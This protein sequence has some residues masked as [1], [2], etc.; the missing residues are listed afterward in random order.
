MKTYSLLKFLNEPVAD[1]LDSGEEYCFKSLSYAAE[2]DYN[3][4]A[5]SQ[6]SVPVIQ[7]DYAQG[8]PENQTMREK[9]IEKIFT[10]LE[11]GEQ[12]KLD[13]IYGT[14]QYTPYG[15]VFMPLDG[16]QRLTTLYL[17]HWYII[18][19][20]TPEESEDYA[21]FNELLSKFSYETRDTSRR[22]F[23]ELIDFSPNGP[24]DRSI[25]DSYWFS[26]HFELDPTV[27][28]VINTLKT[29]EETYLNSI[30]RG[31]LLESL[32]TD[33]IVFYV[34]PMDKFKLTDDL[35]IKLNARGKILSSF[36]NFKADYIG[37][38]KKQKELETD[39]KL[40]NG[41]TMPHYDYIANKFDNDWTNLFWQEAKKQKTSKKNME[42]ADFLD[43]YF[44]RFIHRLFINNFLLTY[45]GSDINKDPVYKELLRKEA[46]LT[47]SDFDF[48]TEHSLISGSTVTE[49]EILLDFYLKH[50]ETIKNLV[51]PLWEISLQWDIYKERYTMTERMIFDAVNHYIINNA[52]D[53]D[54]DQERF[55]EWIRIVWNL[56][57]DPDIRSIEANKTVMG[58]IRSISKYSGRFHSEI[59]TGALDEFITS[60]RNIH[61]AQLQEEKHKAALMEGDS[62]EAKQWKHLIHKAESHKLFEGSIGF[63]LQDAAVPHDLDR[64]LALAE[65][66]F[67]KNRPF[68]LLK[69]QQHTLMRYVIARFKDYSELSAFNFSDNEIN[70]KTYLRRNETVKGIISELINLPSIKEACDK[71]QQALVDNSILVN[72]NSKESKAH[73]NLYSDNIFHSWMQYDG[74]NKLRWREH[75]IYAYRPSA[76]YS[77]VMIDGNRNELTQALIGRFSLEQPNFR[78]RDSNFFMGEAYDLFWRGSGIVITFHFDIQNYLHIGLWS[79]LNPELALKH[80]ITNDWIERYTFAIDNIINMDDV[81]G[82][83]GSFEQKITVENTNSL[84]VPLI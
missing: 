82:F 44:F 47:Y 49:L 70:W 16:Q 2:I 7:R 4:D 76:W 32:L 24:I 42:S 23:N 50:H 39:L 69:N 11:T 54:L 72:A 30:K 10:H 64:R 18:K 60:L 33:T 29:I 15:T 21:G 56:I 43:A 81:K 46:E 38:T 62:S 68:E 57:S 53:S 28:G 35:Y 78:C 14:I 74:V 9:F 22:F 12:L 3:S 80:S 41:I 66:I 84:L 55:R 73:K 48:Y 25:K 67:D 19:K 17:I 75:H 27:S 20:E 26:D 31:A 34:L 45:T 83:I 79:E 65:K 61:K 63:L 71:I 40:P 58:V 51:T 13:F 5:V 1:L 37:F 77:K 36:E 59:I 8:R 52:K 6:V